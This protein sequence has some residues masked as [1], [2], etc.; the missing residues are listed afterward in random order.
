M[1]G[2]DSPTDDPPDDPPKLMVGV[3]AIEP[4]AED[5]G[6]EPPRPVAKA[7]AA[8]PP[9][10]APRMTNFFRELDFSLKTF[11]CGIDALDTVLL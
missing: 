7:A 10:T 5:A 8:A 1:V 3:A 6:P 2:V 9:I 11:V 4:N